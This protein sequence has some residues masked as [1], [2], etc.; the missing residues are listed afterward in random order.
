MKYKSLLLLLLALT[1]LLGSCNN[2]DET[3]LEIQLPIDETYVPATVGVD[4]AG[5]T[6]EQKRNLIHLANNQY[7]INDVS[8][9]PNDLIGFSE[10]FRKIN[11]EEKTMLV[12]YVLHDYT[13]DAYT[14]RYYRD[15]KENSYNWVVG[16]G[17]TS[18]TG[19][20]GED[21]HFTRFA[22]LVR[23]LPADAEV[24]M[25]YGLTSQSR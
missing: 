13:I 22:I 2:N 1:F 4:L 17:T 19:S 24:K 6:E 3:D 11:F 16:V 25:W 14:N 7:V 10:A 8:E 18:D 21:S 20:F 5:I 12:R 15:M 9:L 23:K